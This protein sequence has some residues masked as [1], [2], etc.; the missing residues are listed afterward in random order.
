MRKNEDGGGNM[1]EFEARIYTIGSGSAV[2][3]IP[4]KVF[5]ETDLKVGDHVKVMIA[6]TEE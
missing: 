2:V 3:T 1:V 6:K 5:R 4:S